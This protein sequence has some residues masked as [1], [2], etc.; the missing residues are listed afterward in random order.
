MFGSKATFGTMVI[1]GMTS[2]LAACTV[3]VSPLTLAE[4]VIKDRSFSDIATDNRIVLD[5][6]AAM[7]NAGILSAS[8][9]IYEQRLLVT[10]II[11]NPADYNAFHAD[12]KAISG[13][14]DLYW[15]VVQMSEAEQEAEGDALLS[16]ADTLAL[17]AMVAAN[18]VPATGI[19]EANYRVTTNSFS[20]VYLI[21][22]A[23]SQ[24]ELDDALTAAR[25]TG[26]VKKL[27]NYVEL[28]P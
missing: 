17:E 18:V 14:K 2:A 10:G 24:T 6:N 28:R 22:R 15:H 11:E 27:V 9:E 3:V 7:A 5:A 23:L 13:V 4:R 19:N 26:S 8:T 25:D 16:W 12:I 20:T 21:A 1:A